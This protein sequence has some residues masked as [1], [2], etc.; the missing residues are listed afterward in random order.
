[1][2]VGPLPSVE[3][4]SVQKDQM[5]GLRGSVH[6]FLQFLTKFA[7][8]QMDMAETI[9]CGIAEPIRTLTKEREQ[10]KCGYTFQEEQLR[11]EMVRKRQEFKKKE[12]NDPKIKFGPLV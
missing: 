9:R 8:K 2:G 6:K 12:E 7:S 3:T 10:E 1:M 11:K 5:L 4:G